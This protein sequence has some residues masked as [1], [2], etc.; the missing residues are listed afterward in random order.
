MDTEMWYD[1]DKNPYILFTLTLPSTLNEDMQ[2]ALEC[3]Q[4]PELHGI[5]VPLR[6]RIFDVDSEPYWE[7]PKI[8]ILINMA[9]DKKIIEMMISAVKRIEKIMNE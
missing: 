2:K 5:P 6:I 1:K 3:I 7:N 9:S 8:K 4:F